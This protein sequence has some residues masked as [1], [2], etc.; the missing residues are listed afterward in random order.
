[1][2]ATLVAGAGGVKERMFTD[3][4]GCELGRSIFESM[5]IGCSPDGA[6]E[7]EN[8]IGERDCHAKIAATPNAR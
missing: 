8:V 7:V 4:G 6:S 1:M 5:A 2:A 3:D